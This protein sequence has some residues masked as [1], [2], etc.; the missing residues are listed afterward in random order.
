VADS[1][2]IPH[3]FG[4]CALIMLFFAVGT[5]YNGFFTN[6]N[7]EAYRAQLGQVADYLSSNI[8]DLV[9]LSQL[10][11]GDQFLVKVVEMPTFI[12]ER[13][14]NIS[15][16]TMTPSYGD[17]DLIRIITRIDALN[18]YATSDLPWSL[19]SNIRIYTDQT[20]HAHMSFNKTLTSDAAIG[21]AA[22]TKKPAAMMVWCLKENNNITIGLGVMERGS[23]V[24]P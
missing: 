3:I 20:P 17:A 24:S 19:N 11:E 16:T 15:L 23:E 8:I 9:T 14:Y 4:T 22:K 5:Y 1:T 21:Q 10:T 2:I 6:L 12:G 13:V 18:I 7:S